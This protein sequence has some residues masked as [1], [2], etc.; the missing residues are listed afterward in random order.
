MLEEEE[1]SVEL[2]SRAVKLGASEPV[3]L[4]TRVTTITYPI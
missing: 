4:D 3:W 1:R 2:L